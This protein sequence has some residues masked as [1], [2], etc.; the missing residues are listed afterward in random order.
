MSTVYARALGW[1]T[2][3]G[4]DVL[5]IAFGIL[6]LWLGVL[7]LPPG[8]SP[9]EP[10]MRAA[11]PVFVPMDLFIRFA[12]AWEILVGIGFISGQFP[13]LTLLM[14]FA[15]M[16]TTLSIPWMAPDLV[17]RVFPLVLTFEGE[18]VI[19]DIV[20]AASALV[21]AVTIDGRNGEMEQRLFNAVRL[22]IPTAWRS[23]Y[24]A[25]SAMARAW[26]QRYSLTILRVAFGVV[27]L[28]FGALKVVPGTSALEPLTRVALPIEPFNVFYS[29]L[30]VW[31]TL[32]GLALMTRGLWRWAL[33][34]V[35]VF[36][37]VTSLSVFLRPE[38]MFGEVPGVLTLLGQHMLKNLIFTGAAL[39]LLTGATATRVAIDR[40]AA[41]N[42]SPAL[43]GN[44]L[45]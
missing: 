31:E 6:F 32:I 2:S 13:R 44:W 9:A 42:S 21:L 37:A 40:R 22:P 25:A 33:A 29:G 11:M 38:L 30:G 35:L 19:K 4:R 15:T 7:K 16:C 41:G 18:Y 26:A 17:W 27:F 34:W 23:Q 1:S 8:V 3:Y 36:C 28:V 43:V 10:L 24:R 39:V 45:S 5:R 20:I 12:A 14:T